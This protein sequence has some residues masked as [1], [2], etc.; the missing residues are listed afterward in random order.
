MYRRSSLLALL[1]STE[2][3]GPIVRAGP[4][5]TQSK[6]AHHGR[7]GP[8]HRDRTAGRTYFNWL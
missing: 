1:S 3:T 6:A 2:L 7:R 5:S 8:P 4:I